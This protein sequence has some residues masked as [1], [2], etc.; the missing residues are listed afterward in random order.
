MI[1]AIKN[2]AP[3]AEHRHCARHVYANWKKKWSGPKFKLLFWNAVKSTCESQFKHVMEELKNE[4]V[5]AYE[6]F[7]EKQP[8]AFCKSL[9]DMHTKTDVVDNNICETF[10]SY[11]LKF[12]DEPL[13]DMLD[14]I[15]LNLMTRM[16][17]ISKSICS[18]SD[19]LCP[20]VRKKV[21]R[22]K[23]MVNI[24]TVLA[25]IGGLYEVRSNDDR[26]IV[27][28][29]DRECSCRLWKLTGLPCYHALACINYNRDDPSK[30]MDVF[31]HR[32]TCIEAYKHALKPFPGPKEWPVVN[33][34]PILPPKFVIQPGRPKKARR[35][36]P[37]EEP[38]NGNKK[39]SK[40]G[41][42]MT[43][44]A[45]GQFGHNISTCSTIDRSLQP[46]AQ[47]ASKRKPGRPKKVIDP[48]ASDPSLQS[49]VQIAPKRKPGRP[50]KV[51][52]PNSEAS[53]SVQP[54][55]KVNFSFSFFYTVLFIFCKLLIFV[56]LLRGNVEDLQSQ[57]QHML[58]MRGRKLREERR[59]WYIF[60]Y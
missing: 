57:N 8:K 13:I 56:I 30:Y 1:G 21:E 48:S 39:W 49:E 4:S 6:D 32:S 5:L 10:N 9:V 44:R 18:S 14:D 42:K 3:H 47:D 55:S 51:I 19:I 28:L 16:Q 58:M 41:V 26:Y 52:D 27:N 40:R 20:N 29:R 45:C 15:R 7:C 2:L 50:K 11:I 23:G 12:R 59:D 54:K 43:C 24:W 37:T 38:K 22:M 31:Y 33:E 17:A 34:P 25:A 35:K 46:E 60:I 36:D 53:S